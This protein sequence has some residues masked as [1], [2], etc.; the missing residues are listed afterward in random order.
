MNTILPISIF[1]ISA[2]F[3]INILSARQL[4][5]EKIGF[6]NPKQ[7]DKFNNFVRYNKEYS[8]KMKGVP[9]QKQHFI[10]DNIKL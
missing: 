3:G 5:K 1:I 2:L 7:E 8:R 6:I 10:R 9:T 4:F